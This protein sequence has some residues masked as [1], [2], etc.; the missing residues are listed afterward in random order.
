MDISKVRLRFQKAWNFTV[1]TN[2]SV[3]IS[4]ARYSLQ[5]ESLNSKD[6]LLYVTCKTMPLIESHVIEGEGQRWIVYLA[7]KEV[8]NT[9]LYE[10]RLFPVT[11][12]FTLEALNIATNDLGMMPA[13]GDG[14]TT[15]VDCYIEEYS[16]KERTVPTAQPVESYQQSFIVAASSIPDYHGAYKIYYKGIKFKVDSFERTAGM[17]RIRATEDL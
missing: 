12:S 2:A 16:L 5:Q 9:D 11:G 17:V 8:V 4:Q 10:F 3:I 13:S 14:E 6:M 15:E 1:L 7:M